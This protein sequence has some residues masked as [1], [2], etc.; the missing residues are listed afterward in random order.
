MPSNLQS[1]VYTNESGTAPS[2]SVLDQLLVPHEK[3]YIPVP[4][5]E[6]SWSVIRSMQ[7]RGE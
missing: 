1:L 6:T 3:V 2:L 5:V 7:I 4:D